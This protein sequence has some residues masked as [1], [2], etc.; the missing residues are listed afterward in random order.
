MAMRSS[1]LCLALLLL[2]AS[3]AAGQAQ[4]QQPPR[5]AA[6]VNGDGGKKKSDDGNDKKEIVFA[7]PGAT[8]AS[9]TL[10]RDKFGGLRR[11]ENVV[12]DFLAMRRREKRAARAI[13]LKGSRGAAKLADAPPKDE[14][15]PP[16]KE[17]GASEGDESEPTT[18]DCYQSLLLSPL[19]GTL[20][21]PPTQVAA[22]Q[23]VAT[24]G[25]GG[26]GGGK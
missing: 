21:L 25:G 8:K 11:P 20:C 12:A 4:Q 3:A 16:A 9:L 1:S 23:K 22:E 14:K 7:K 6:A 15:Q 13:L 19:L 24:P 18:G 2:L 26:G 5:G 10:N 17:E